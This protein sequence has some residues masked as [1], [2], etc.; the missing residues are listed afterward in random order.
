MLQ[1]RYICSICLAY[2]NGFTQ[3]K[4]IVSWWKTNEVVCE[5]FSSEL[6][7][8]NVH[9]KVIVKNF[10][11]LVINKQSSRI[12]VFYLVLGFLSL[13]IERIEKLLYLNNKEVIVCV[14]SIQEKLSLSGN[15]C[16][17]SNLML[18]DLV[19]CVRFLGSCTAY[20]HPPFCRLGDEIS[21][22]F[23]KWGVR[24]I[25]NFQRE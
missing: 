18:Q 15:H 5:K 25:Q 12:C 6:I 2:Q 4:K 17:C 24:K 11:W 23:D 13:Q 14:F 7:Y 3:L 10:L 9:R 16:F 1:L 20:F 8:L 19:F 21:K 22:K